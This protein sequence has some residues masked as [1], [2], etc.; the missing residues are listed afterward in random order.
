[1]RDAQVVQH[2]NYI[3]NRLPYRR[4]DPIAP[5]ASGELIRV[6]GEAH[7]AYETAPAKLPSRFVIPVQVAAA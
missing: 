1:M 7:V 2:Q 5:C 6:R 3:A 4:G